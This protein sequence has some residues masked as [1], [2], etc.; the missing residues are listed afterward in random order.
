MAT[1]VPEPLGGTCASCACLLPGTDSSEA[2]TP[3]CAP[4]TEG[5]SRFPESGNCSCSTDGFVLHHG[6]K[7]DS[8]R[9]PHQSEF[10]SDGSQFHRLAG[11]GV[12]VGAGADSCMRTG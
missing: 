10:S 1:C 2:R 4:G 7:L 11:R 5:V 3:T 6:T 8:G 12:L 9:V